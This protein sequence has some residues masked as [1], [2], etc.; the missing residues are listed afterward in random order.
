M[1]EVVCVYAALKKRVSCAVYSQNVVHNTRECVGKKDLILLE[2]T[3][4]MVVRACK[5]LP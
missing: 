3:T 1:A 2:H 4:D 5:L